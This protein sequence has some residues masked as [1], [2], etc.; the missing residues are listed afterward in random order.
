MYGKV[1]IIRASTVPESLDTFCR[2]LLSELQQECGYEVVAVSSP[3]DRLDTLAAREGV[4]TV[5][6][7][8]PPLPEA[9]QPILSLFTPS[10]MLIT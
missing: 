3:G 9:G 6:V 5:A 4:R 7:T 2:G 10:A 1:K 8:D